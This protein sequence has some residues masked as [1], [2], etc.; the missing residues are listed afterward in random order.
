[1]P[2]WTHGLSAMGKK[3]AGITT[4]KASESDGAVYVDA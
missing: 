1:M 2:T 3:P 4:F